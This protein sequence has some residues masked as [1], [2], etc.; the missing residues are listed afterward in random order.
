MEIETSNKFLSDEFKLL[1]KDSIAHALPFYISRGYV[2]PRE[3]AINSI[4]FSKCKNPPSM[5]FDPA[6]TPYLLPVLDAWD[7]SGVK[8]EITVVAPE[9]TGKTLSWLIPLLWS[10]EHKAGTSIAVYPSDDLCQR[11][12]E[13]KL[14]PL[15]Q[16]I[17]ALAEQ[18]AMPR[19]K[20]VNSYN[21]AE[22]ISY[23]WGAGARVTSISA[24]ICIADEIDDW[25]EHEGQVS[26]LEDLRKRLRAFRESILCKVCTP[27]TDAAPIW[28]EFKQSSKGYW[29]LR[30]LKC[31]G[32]TMRSCD[33]YN[34]QFEVKDVDKHKE[35]VIG[36][37]R[38]RCPVCRH[39]HMESDRAIQNAQ[40]DYIHQHPDA[41]EIS[42]GFQ[43]GGLANHVMPDFSYTKLARAQLLAGKSGS[44][45][46]QRFFDNSIRGL[47][48]ETRA[49][50]G[51]TEDKLNKHCPRFLPDP[52]TLEAIFIS[53]DTQ[54]YGWKWELRGFDI[55]SNRWL[56]GYGLC[57]YLELTDDERAVINERLQKTALELG[58]EHHDIVTVAD[59]L[60]KEWNGIA[61]LLAIMDEGGHRKREV[62]PFVQAHD[63]LYSYKGN[64]QG[65][66]KWRLS[67]NLPK[68]ILAHEKDYQADLIYYL[69]AQNNTENNYWYLMPE[70]GQDYLK[71]IAAV[72]ADYKKRDG[73]Q[74]ENWE[75]NGKV[76]DFFD[77]GKMY[78]VIED[79]AVS[80]LERR[81]F[82]HNKAEILRVVNPLESETAALNATAVN[83]KKSWVKGY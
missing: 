4:D 67:E 6:M 81:Y 24:N 39:E 28:S 68:L 63:K 65:L 80:S 58:E 14:L 53:I 40:G 17:P 56:L 30:C 82:R 60:Y 11:I 75:H 61:P 26:N 16:A 73:D 34:L 41:I 62:F 42:P 64:N 5:R 47:P 1:I 83:T 10:F 52:E 51:D 22:S 18:L 71:E 12:N 27:T 35:L 36:S 59:I 48:F 31:G 29:H 70:I 15:M 76:H 32:L 66:E 57:E 54:D 21:F 3:Y 37:E 20:R 45:K 38:L 69:Y 74:Y 78:L 49:I 79:V 7:F 44:V 8:K 55:N 43:W 33:I 77:T 9:Q 19:S 13:T 2:S 23:F 72:Q 46:S 25:T 50:L